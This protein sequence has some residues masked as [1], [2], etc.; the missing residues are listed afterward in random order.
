ME[1]YRFF[2]KIRDMVSS[3]IEKKEKESVIADDISFC[4]VN[5]VMNAIHGCSM[6]F[7]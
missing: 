7:C 4:V 1:K 5:C 2:Q 6:R 3:G